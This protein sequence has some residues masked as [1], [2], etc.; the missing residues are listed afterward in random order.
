[1]NRR[2]FLRLAPL[3][4]AADPLQLPV[5]AADRKPNLLLI[6]ATD[7]R[8]QS[9]PWSGDENIVAPNLTKF[10]RQSLTFSRAY[11]CCSR[12]DRALFSLFRAVY[13]HTLAAPSATTE[14]LVS[15][16]L[17]IH[18]VLKNSGYR[19]S[20]FDSLQAEDL[21]SFAHDSAKEP[22]FA[23]WTFA[24]VGVSLMERMDATGI[25]LRENVPSVLDQRSR[26]ELAIFY[27]R[28]KTRDREIGVVFEALDRPVLADNTIVVFTSDHGELYGSHGSFGDDYPYEESIRVPLAIRYPKVLPAGKQSD[29]LVS[30]ADIVPSLLN[31]CG[32]VAPET[33][34]GRDLSSLWT[35][36][37]S[38][39]PESL[40]AEG[41]LG[42]ADEWRMI[43]RGYDKLVSEADGKVSHLY[44]LADDP[45]EITNLANSSTAQ[46]K[47]DSLLALQKTWARKLGDG[48]DA[49]G[50]RKR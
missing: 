16:A 21:V 19:V 9:V 33:A 35:G 39:R 36:K 6:V 41:R 31:L 44:N 42:H 8:A 34:Q 14:E 5:W 12:S 7:W 15:D 2:T 50:L 24:N 20:R 29:I 40:Y 18:T 46:L 10:G 43:V 1:M 47:Q 25:R 27:A 45:N 11:A 28:A 48:V 30:Q 17:P 49:S 22:F 32:A 37:A 23:E 38:E 4:L 3:A 13:P 26:D